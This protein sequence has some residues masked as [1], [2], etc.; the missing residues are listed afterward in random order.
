MFSGV[1]HMDGAIDLLYVTWDGPGS[2]YLE[3]LFLPALEALAPYGI[4][5]TVLQFSWDIGP[6]AEATS[7]AAASRGIG[8]VVR[9]VPRWP[10]QAA[11]AAAI[12]YGAFHVASVARRLRAGVIMPRSHIPAAMVLAA[13]P[14]LP[15][16]R[17]VWDSDG[18]MPEE[19]VEFAGWKPTGLQYRAF[20]QLE[21]ATVRKAALTLTRT[22]AARELLAE[23]ARVDSTCFMVVPNGKDPGQFRPGTPEERREGRLALG[24]PFDAPVLAYV[25]S[26]GPQYRLP[27]MLQVF[28][29]VRARRPETRFV[30]LSAGVDGVRA[31][32]AAAGIP[33]DAL[34]V[35]A[36]PADGVPR[37]LRA[38]DVGFALRQP[39]VSQRAV[40][41]IKVGEYLLSGVPVLANRGVGDLDERF[42]SARAVAFARDFSKDE[43]AGLAAAVTERFLPD[44]EAM[45]EDA[46]TLGLDHY[47]LAASARGY[48][49]AI[50]QSASKFET[51]RSR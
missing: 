41:P 17:I 23:R 29:H 12:G 21:R 26:I 7:R 48:A 2:H 34:V 40:C 5:A 10:L 16:A 14:A 8:Y 4:R 44:R 45:R 49:R 27:E 43:L 18:L 15:H 36:V 32:A 20:R 50:Q 19:R 42:G 28:Q 37:L 11:T 30:V 47:S 13:T 22:A 31:A 24:V 33:A 46:R 1:R 51:H 3:S 9:S 35:R 25:G 6:W 38:C 39:S